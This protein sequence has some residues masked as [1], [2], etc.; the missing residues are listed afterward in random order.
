M[1]SLHFYWF[2][3]T[4]LHL[5]QNKAVFF[6][7]ITLDFIEIL[8]LLIHFEALREPLMRLPAAFIHYLKLYN[9]DMIFQNNFDQINFIL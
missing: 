2:C 5:Q 4:V 1:V 9:V 8:P 6:S 3:V 7:L